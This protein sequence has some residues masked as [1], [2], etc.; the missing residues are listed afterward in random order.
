MSDL[1][2]ST[3]NATLLTDV[4]TFRYW[5]SGIA[6]II[7]CI[8][9]LLGNTLNA[10]IQFKM[11][12]STLRKSHA[13]ASTT[14]FLLVMAICDILVLLFYLIYDLI[15]L[16]RPTRRPLLVVQDTKGLEG[17]FTYFIYFVWYFPANVFITC[18]NWCIVAVMAFRF[19]AVYFPLRA[20]TWCS[21]NRAKN[22]LILIFIA[23]IF[24]TIPDMFMIKLV[25]SDES[26]FEF[27][28][29]NLSNNDTFARIY[30]SLL[31]AFN[32]FLPF[33]ICTLLSI[34]LIRTLKRANSK[35]VK[36]KSI[37]CRQSEV[38]KQRKISIMLLC[39]TSWFIF[40][41]CPSFVCRILTLLR[42]THD[43]GFYERFRGIADLIL[44]LN[45]TANFVLYAITNEAYRRC[46]FDLVLCRNRR[47]LERQL[48]VTLLNSSIRSTRASYGHHHSPG[49]D[50]GT[51][52]KQH[53]LVAGGSNQ[54]D[55]GSERDLNAD[56]S[57]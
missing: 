20:K 42:N 57:F 24:I 23:A 45:H 28:D 7:I 14:S 10:V 25:T 2:N 22:L 9:G 37:R 53:L 35:L 21:L 11:L 15:C 40:C 3:G 43:I 19:V 27:T 56:L 31:E 6:G 46:L 54:Y 13:A 50:I 4:Y 1:I 49:N 30:F 29:T 38:N 44:L 51:T 55:D 32:S 26:V 36:K 34:M 39:V 8:I 12:R 5:L 17:T 41:T 18:S 48:T 47:D 52:T 33:I 16:A